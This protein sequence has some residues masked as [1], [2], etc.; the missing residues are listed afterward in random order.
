[1]FIFPHWCSSY[2][3]CNFFKSVCKPCHGCGASLTDS[4]EDIFSIGEGQQTSTITSCDDYNEWVDLTK[5]EKMAHLDKYYCFDGLVI[6]PD[7][8]DILEDLA[9]SND[10]DHM[11]CDEFNNAYDLED[12]L[13]HRRRLH[14][15]DLHLC[16]APDETKT[17]KS[18]K[19]KSGTSKTAKTQGKTSK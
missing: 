9:D 6:N 2:C 14:E 11:S 10:N 18:D 16:L 12:K 7:I 3:L 15:E 5:E 8:I 13:E 1:M 19:N 17:S 4:N